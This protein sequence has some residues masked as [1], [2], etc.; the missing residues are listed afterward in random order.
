VKY[1]ATE[2]HQSILQYDARMKVHNAA[3]QAAV[4]DAIAEKYDDVF[5][6]KQA[7]IEALDWLLERLSPGAR[8]LDV[9]S[10]TGLPT[11]KALA[12]AGHEVHGID[13]SGEMV[14]IARRNVPAGRFDQ[15]DVLRLIQPDAHYDAAM[16]F[17]SLLMLPKDGVRQ[18]LG[19]LRRVLRPG[20]YFLVSMVEGDLDYESLEFM[21]Q[22]VRLTAFPQAALEALLRE[23][24]FEVLDARGVSFTPREGAEPER[25]LFY[26]CRI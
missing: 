3:L 14:R 5:S 9:G 23:Q 2:Q 4:F 11:A 16:A 12:D 22:V 18:A 26:R 20:G 10:G 24:E 8:V 19:M 25:Q 7:Q 15:V 17:F 1:V 21:G 13:I 6:D